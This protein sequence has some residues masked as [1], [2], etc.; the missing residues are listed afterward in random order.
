MVL[1]PFTLLELAPTLCAQSV[2]SRPP[3]EPVEIARGEQ[4]IVVSDTPIASDVG[5]KLLKDGGNAIDAAIGV[6]FALQVSWPEAGNIGG[7]GF[8]MIAPWN[9]RELGKR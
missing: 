9:H 4:G 7:G 3:R 1:L 5:C 8:M 2:L 6:A